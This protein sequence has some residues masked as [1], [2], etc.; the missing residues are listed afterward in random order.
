M[1]S[2]PD[3]TVWFDQLLNSRAHLVQDRGT[4][5]RVNLTVKD[6]DRCRLIRVGR[7]AG[8]GVLQAGSGEDLVLQSGER[9]GASAALSILLHGDPGKRDGRHGEFWLL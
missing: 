3:Q 5:G 6:L 7:L 8:V 1:A 4:D 9:L 2:R